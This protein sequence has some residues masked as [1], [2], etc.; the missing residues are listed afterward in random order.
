MPSQKLNLKFYQEHLGLENALFSLIEHDDAI[1]AIVYKV[2]ESNGRDSILKI[3]EHRDHF[4]REVFFLNALK[5]SSPV[6]K[7]LHSIKPSPEAHG[8]IL[9]EYLPGQVLSQT[10]LTTKL[11]E[12]AGYELARIHQNR[13]KGYGDLIREES[14]SPNPRDHF[15]HKFEEGLSECQPHLPAELTSKCHRDF[16]THLHLLELADGPCFIHRDFRPGNLIAHENTLLG[17]IDWASARSGFAQE[18]FCSLDMGD[19]SEKVEIQAAFLSGYESVRP[20]PNFQEMMPLLRLNRSIAILGYLFREGTWQST[21]KNLYQTH[22][23]LLK[24]PFDQ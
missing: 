18:D 1:V 24:A 8:A 10:T 23:Q 3:C 16:H 14:L 4:Y 9:M 21:C 13:T 22:L 12:K 11:A 7:I 6:P 19:W 15:T 5:K 2:T 20:L 17:I